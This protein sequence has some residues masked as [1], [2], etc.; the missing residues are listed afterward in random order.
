MTAETGGSAKS[1]KK[2]FIVKR[3]LLV[4]YKKTFHAEE[5]SC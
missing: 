1:T 2:F 4:I 3:L 5:Y